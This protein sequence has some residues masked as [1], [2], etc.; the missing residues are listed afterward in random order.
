MLLKKYLALEDGSNGVGFLWLD[1]DHRRQLPS[2]RNLKSRFPSHRSCHCIRISEGPWEYHIELIII[3]NQRAR[4]R[5][6]ERGVL[7]VAGF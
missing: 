3:F 5:M 1:Y 6:E 2:F 4:G 7:R